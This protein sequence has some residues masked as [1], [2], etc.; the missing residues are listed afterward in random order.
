[1]YSPPGAIIVAIDSCLC[2]KLCLAFTSK[3]D[4]QNGLKCRTV[5]AEQEVDRG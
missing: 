1:M 2:D 3:H 4:K 5:H